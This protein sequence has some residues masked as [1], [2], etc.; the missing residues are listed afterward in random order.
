MKLK[1]TLVTSA[2]CLCVGSLY[3]DDK[4][5]NGLLRGRYNTETSPAKA[6]VEIRDP[7]G[8]DREKRLEIKTD[9]SD[10][11][12]HDAK[13]AHHDA[14]LQ[15]TMEKTTKASD[16]MGMKVKNSQGETLGSIS[17]MALD[18]NSGRISYAVLSSGGILGFRDRLYAIPLSA[19]HRGAEDKVLMLDVDK[20]TLQNTP[21]FVKTAWPERADETI[22]NRAGRAIRDPAGAK[23]K[24]DG[25]RDSGIKIDSDRDRLKIEKDGDTKLKVERKD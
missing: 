25:D 17:D 13:G 20:E 15:G 11:L 19:L 24:V 12:H 5:T 9:T 1:S 2:L 3:A 14:S 18:L 6:G 10:A 7:A 22:F 4:S 23:I 8:A 16:L 21:G